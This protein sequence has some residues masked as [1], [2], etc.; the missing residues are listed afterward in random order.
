MK[1]I[2]LILATFVSL[3]SFA[4][5]PESIKCTND[6]G[7]S[8]ELT[9]TPTE[10]AVPI[11]KLTLSFEGRQIEAFNAELRENSD[12]SFR[13]ETSK[14]EGSKIISAG[15]LFTDKLEGFYQEIANSGL[16]PLPEVPFQNCTIK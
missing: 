6:R 5:L 1:K 7:L 14:E 4:S 10:A 11:Y 12:Y 2:I 9:L 13:V 15:I 16:I 8:M 3:T